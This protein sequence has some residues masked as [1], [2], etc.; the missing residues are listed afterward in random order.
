M[1]LDKLFDDIKSFARERYEQ[2]IAAAEQRG[3]DSIFLRAFGEGASYERSTMELERRLAD[4][5]N[6]A[7]MSPSEYAFHVA[8]LQ[9]EINPFDS[10]DKSH[11][12]R[13]RDQIDTIGSMLSRRKLEKATDDEVVLYSAHNPT[14][15]T[16]KPKKYLHTIKTQGGDVIQHVAEKHSVWPLGEDFFKRLS[17]FESILDTEPF[18]EFTE[19]C[20]WTCKEIQEPEETP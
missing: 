14:D 2:E 19:E 12:A 20:D 9:D 3:R 11:V 6:V 7:A 8:K 15:T 1:S 13:L 16:P 18:V 17:L 5:P 10:W 4:D